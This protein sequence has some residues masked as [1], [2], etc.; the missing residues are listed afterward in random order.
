MGRKTTHSDPFEIDELDIFEDTVED[1]LNPETYRDHLDDQTYMRQRQRL[2]EMKSKGKRRGGGNRYGW[3]FFL[4]SLFVGLGF[5]AMTEAP[6][7]LFLGL[8]IGFL[9]FVDPIY[10]KVMKIIDRI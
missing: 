2:R 5:T 7:P 1:D 6:L 4:C 9:F 8:G 3:A 10:E